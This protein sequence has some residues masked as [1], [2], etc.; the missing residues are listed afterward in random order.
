M[1]LGPLKL[2][3]DPTVV[4]VTQSSVK[5]VQSLK[6][7]FCISEKINNIVSIGSDE[8][9]LSIEI[10]IKKRIFKENR[11]SFKSLSGRV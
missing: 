4:K 2:F 11:E 6:M 7:T 10:V 9:P 5:S 3:V 8:S 1:S